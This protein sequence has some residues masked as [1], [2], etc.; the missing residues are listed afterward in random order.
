MQNWGPHALKALYPRGVIL[1]GGDLGV[2]LLVKQLQLL[3]FM[4]DVVMIDR[5]L[6]SLAV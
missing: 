2:K 5:H 4:E 6:I 1:E 3:L